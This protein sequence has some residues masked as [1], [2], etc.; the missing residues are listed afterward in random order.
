MDTGFNGGARIGVN[1]DSYLPL[2]GFSLEADSFYTQSHYSGVPGA[3]LGSASFMGDLIY[4]VP[5]G[6]NWGFYGG[7]GLGAVD[8]MLHGPAHG[9]QTVLG[10]QALG[11]VEYAIS[12]DMSLFTEYRYQNAHDAHIGG[13]TNVGNTSD[14]VSVGVKFGL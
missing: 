12:P 11:G 7:A 6:T 1:L 2:R 14:N 4:H 9:A 10:W 13:L 8:D 3:K 5:T